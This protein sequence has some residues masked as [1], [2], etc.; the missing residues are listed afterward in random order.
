MKST[1]VSVSSVPVA[2]TVSR[3]LAILFHPVIGGNSLEISLLELSRFANVPPAVESLETLPLVPGNGPD[4]HGQAAPSCSRSMSTPGVINIAVNAVAAA[5]CH[6]STLPVN[7]PTPQWTSLR[8]FRRF[9]VNLLSSCATP[10]GFRSSFSLGHL[11][12]FVHSS[13]TFVDATCNTRRSLSSG[14]F[15]KVCTALISTEMN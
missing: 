5:L 9:N 2:V 6:P 7:K 13:V 11:Y 1:G 4:R 8:H 10:D 12:I 3:P 15:S 14:P